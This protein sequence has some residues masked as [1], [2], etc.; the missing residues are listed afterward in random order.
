MNLLSF[1][2]IIQQAVCIGYWV[3]GIVLL[4]SS[5]LVKNLENEEVQSPKSFFVLYFHC[6]HVLMHCHSLFIDKPA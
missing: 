4:L 3:L 5:S 6:S 1:V 2:F